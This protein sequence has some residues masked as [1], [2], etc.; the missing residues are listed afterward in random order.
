MHLFSSFLKNK[1][2]DK[3][4]TANLSINP[5]MHSNSIPILKNYSDNKN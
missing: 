1:N 5:A 2:S 4:I 3:T